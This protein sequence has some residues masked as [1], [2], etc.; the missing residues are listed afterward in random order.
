[1]GD[2][3]RLGD[4]LASQEPVR[5]DLRERYEQ[6]VRQMFE[7]E[8]NVIQRVVCSLAAV[9][10][11]AMAAVFG[12]LAV[13]TTE[14]P[15]LARGI[16]GIGA[17]FGLVWVGMMVRILRRGSMHTVL[18][19]NAQGGWAY[20]VTC[21]IAVSTLMLG[22][23]NPDATRSVF[24]VVSAL[25]FFL[26][27]CVALL[28]ARIQQSEMKTREKMLEIEYRLLEIAESLQAKP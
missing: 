15:A 26:G 22:G 12:W 27:G 2:E 10:A 18:D 6:E 17:I 28:L 20:G 8:L 23:Q 5:P 11:S 9:V 7:K 25:V 24:M 14:I 16:F 21:L 1:M 13:T 3:T 19:E 4:L